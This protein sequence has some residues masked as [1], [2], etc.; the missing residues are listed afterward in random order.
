M[1]HNIFLDTTIT[2][3]PFHTLRALL[4]N[5]KTLGVWWWLRCFTQNVVLSM[6]ECTRRMAAL[7]CV[8][9][10]HDCGSVDVSCLSA[11]EGARV[12]EQVSSIEAEL[13]YGRCEVALIPS[14]TR[15]RGSLRAIISPRPKT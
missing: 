2:G 1:R 14:H 6:F 9:D 13:R 3:S 11:A 10:H 8:S 5:V 15:P 7:S 12:Q 4:W